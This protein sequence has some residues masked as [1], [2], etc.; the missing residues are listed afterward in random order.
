MSRKHRILISSTSRQWREDWRS[1]YPTG[2]SSQTAW[3]VGASVDASNAALSINLIHLM[4]LTSWT[5][6][7]RMSASVSSLCF[8]NTSCGIYMRHDAVT[9]DHIASMLNVHLFMLEDDNKYGCYLLFMAETAQP[10]VYRL[11]KCCFCHEIFLWTPE[12]Y[13]PRVP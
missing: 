4:K 8:A 7:L 6:A 10:H 1:A 13:H 2:L 9:L 5:K 11:I 12:K 3:H